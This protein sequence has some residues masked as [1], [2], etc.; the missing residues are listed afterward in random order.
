MLRAY[1]TFSE[2]AGRNT[3]IQFHRLGLTMLILSLLGGM[4]FLI[5]GA[6]DVAIVIWAFTLGPA[7][8]LLIAGVVQ[9]RHWQRERNRHSSDQHTSSGTP[10]R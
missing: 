1:N 3:M 8:A 10:Q 5:I 2:E 9:R 4:T 6:T 7:I